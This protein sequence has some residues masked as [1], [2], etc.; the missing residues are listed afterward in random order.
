MSINRFRAVSSTALFV[1]LFGG[2]GASPV[3]AG[4]AT[5]PRISDVLRG[6]LQ[7][8]LS[9]NAGPEHISA[10]SLSVLLPGRGGE[11]DVAAGTTS[12]GGTTAV[13]PSNVFQI[14]SNT[15]SFTAVALL[16]LE[17]AGKLSIGDT[18]GKWLPQYPQWKSIKIAQLLDMTS[19][20]AS[21]DN[22]RA[23]EKSATTQ[24]YRTL[25][26]E[27]LIGFVATAPPLKAGWNYSN[28]GYI[29]A[30]LIIE[31]ASH[32]SY[33]SYIAGVIAQAALHDTYYQPSF[34][35]ADVFDRLVD[36]YYD[37]NDPGNEGLAPLL[38]KNVRS[39]SLSWTQAAGGIVATP[40]DVAKWAHDLYTGPILAPKQRAELD[41]LVSTKTGLPIPATSDAEP[42]GFG[43]G[44]TEMHKT[45]IGTFRFYE[46]ETLGYRVAHIY[47]PATDTTIAVGLNSQAAGSKDQAGPLLSQIY[48][49]LEDQGLVPA[50]A[51]RGQRP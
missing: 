3:H 16:H 14:G 19:R 40:A 10:A 47:I 26:A 5:A 48:Q 28:T 36:G 7:A 41:S 50:P 42:R 44:I 39:Y 29:L 22:T 17:A 12:V 25:S 8:Y 11:I 51:A 2:L 43:L 21:Y 35:P 9:K 38:G 24:P 4:N 23:W 33:T 46:G 30:Q 49:T 1:A 20:I 18:V 45:P 27:D 13:T 37:N 15:K 6:E 31:R 32:Q 34:Y